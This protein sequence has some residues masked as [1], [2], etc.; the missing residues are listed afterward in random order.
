MAAMRAWWVIALSIAASRAHAEEP[1]DAQDIAPDE[2][3]ADPTPVPAPAPSPAPAP[4]PPNEPA[5]RAHPV[6][7]MD[8]V[9]IPASYLRFGINFFGDTSFAVT[10]PGSPHSVFTIGTLGV[11]MLGELSPS[12]DALAEVAFE[13]AYGEVLADVEQV[14]IRWRHGRGKLEVGRLHTDIGYWNRAYHHGLWLQTPVARPTALRFEDDGGIIPVHWLGVHY[15]LEPTD[16]LGI[17]LGVGNGRGD[18]VD[19]ILVNRETN[20]G[21]SAL[22]KVRFKTPLVEAGFGAIYD[23]IAPAGAMIRPRLPDERIHEL[24]GNLYVAVRGE[25]PIVIGEGYVIRHQAAG[26]HWVTYAVYGLVGYTLGERVTPYVGIDI[27]QGADE[28]PFFHPDPPMSPAIDMVELLGGTRIDVSTW[29]ALKL[30]LHVDHPFDATSENE[31]TGVIN[32]SFGL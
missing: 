10:T 14:L 12:L 8:E 25:G 13:N 4:A 3:A 32:W 5:K 11:R 1:D 31:Y 9:A 30:E 21:K 27:I 17:V 28:D 26:E 18:I 22:L 24:I 7:T 15:T 29:S 16:E 23:L 20:D 6:H 19:D 2:A